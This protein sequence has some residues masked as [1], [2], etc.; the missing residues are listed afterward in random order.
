MVFVRGKPF[1]SSLMFA[2]KAGAY[3]RMEN[4]KIRWAYLETFN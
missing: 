3:L 2:G 4:L 1:Q